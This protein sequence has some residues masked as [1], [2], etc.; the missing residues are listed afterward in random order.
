[1]AKLQ[2]VVER[3][4]LRAMYYRVPRSYPGCTIKASLANPKKNRYSDISACKLFSSGHWNDSHMTSIYNGFENAV[5]LL[6]SLILSYGASRRNS[7]TVLRWGRVL[8][9]DATSGNTLRKKSFVFDLFPIRIL[10]NFYTP[11]NHIADDS[12][13]VILTPTEFNGQSDYINANYVNVRSFF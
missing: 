6:A 2:G 3:Q 12:T 7:F 8:L 1:M 4:T 9:S 13:R 5:F 11:A 10:S